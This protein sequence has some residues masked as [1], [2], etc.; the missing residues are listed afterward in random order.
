MTFSVIKFTQT[1]ISLRY[2]GTATSYL[3]SKPSIHSPNSISHLSSPRSTRCPIPISLLTLHQPEKHNHIQSTGKMKSF[4][5]LVV[6]VLALATFASAG[7]RN[8]VPGGTILDI[9]HHARG[10]SGPRS[11]RSLL[12]RHRAAVVNNQ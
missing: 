2:K 7:K 11:V 4:T 6:A 3:S 10:I 5:Y 8:F 1:E 12:G 9:G